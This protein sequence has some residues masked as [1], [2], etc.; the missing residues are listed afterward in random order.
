[1][2][3]APADRPPPLAAR[4]VA[5]GAIA[6]LALLAVAVVLPGRG[7]PY[8]HDALSAFERTEWFRRAFLAGDLFPTWS[9]FCFNGHGTPGPFFYHRL[10]YTVSGALAAAGLSSLRAVT[11][12]VVLFLAVG[13]LGMERL[14]RALGWPLAVRLAAAALLILAPYTYT[15]WL[16]RAALAELAAGMLVPWLFVHALRVM[17]GERAGVAL[18]TVWALLFYAHVV[19]WLYATIFVA[20]AFAWALVAQRAARR[21]APWRSPVGSSLLWTALVLAATAGVYAVAIRRLGPAFDLDRLRVYQPAELF[22]I[23][24]RY[25]SVFNFRWGEQ[26]QGLSVE[27]GRAPLLG[28]LALAPFAAG[29]R[30]RLS[31][32]ALLLLGGGALVCF[33]LQ[34]EL[35]APFY[36]RVPLVDVIQ[37]PW[38]LLAFMAPAAVALFCELAAAVAHGPARGPRVVA[39]VVVAAAVGWQVLFAAR[40]QHIRYGWHR[41]EEIARALDALDGPW[42]GGEFLARGVAPVP[43]RAPFVALDGC[44]LRG[45]SPARDLAQPF[46]FTRLALEVD[47]GPGCTIHFSQFATPFVG[48]EGVPPEAVRR[49]PHGTLDVVLGPGRHRLAFARRGVLAALWATR[50]RGR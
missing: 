16:V 47:A 15:D 6:G 43:P 1:M 11:V 44:A 31:R 36:R 30:G 8:N 28:L 7:W 23:P 48:V 5:G 3:P 22:Q 17:R 46:H 40:A 26:W 29:A 24:K 14:G 25:L 4:L 49:S 50:D 39:G 19:L 12:A 38:R 35:A 33:A 2:D 20:L 32:P 13:G 37:F 21:R 18:G 34:L 10:F 9:P 45:S 27:I 42:A 41:A